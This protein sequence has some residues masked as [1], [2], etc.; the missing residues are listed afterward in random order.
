M[1]SKPDSKL[2]VRPQ[3]HAQPRRGAVAVEA[4][5][6]LPVMVALMLGM[7]DLGRVAQ[8]SRLVE[9]AAREGARFAAGG[10]NNGTV[11]T[12]ANVQTAVQNY[13]TAGGMPATA[14]NGAVI[15]VT[16][17]SSDTWT[18]P[19]NALPL[20]Q[21]QV[22]VTIPAGAPYQSLKLITATM[23]GVTSLQQTV[24]WLSANDALVVVNTQLP[25]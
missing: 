10:T 17:Q 5:V 7:W 6:C 11:V 9:D 15:T 20:D 12:V 25:Y 21:F 13:L 18:N 23:C 19:G 2:A 24:T 22:T 4:A 8:M 1:P 14:V 3:R 16:N